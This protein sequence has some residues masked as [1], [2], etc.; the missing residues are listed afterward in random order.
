MALG[1][2][3]YI[4]LSV[5]PPLCCPKK[6]GCNALFHTHARKLYHWSRRDSRLWL[7]DMDRVWLQLMRMAHAL[8]DHRFAAGRVGV[9]AQTLNAYK[10]I[11]KNARRRHGDSGDP[12]GPEMLAAV[13]DVELQ[14][15]KKAGYK[16]MAAARVGTV[17]TNGSVPCA[18]GASRPPGTDQQ[19]VQQAEVTSLVGVTPTVPACSTP[20]TAMRSSDPR[21][22]DDASSST[23]S[24]S[25]LSYRSGRHI[26]DNLGIESESSSSCSA[27]AAAA[28]GADKSVNEH[29]RAERRAEVELLRDEVEI[30]ERQLKSKQLELE[31]RRAEL[32]LRMKEQA[33]EQA[34][35]TQQRNHDHRQQAQQA[36][37]RRERRKRVRSA[38]PPP[39][40]PR[41]PAAPP[42]PPARP[43]LPSKWHKKWHVDGSETRKNGGNV[44]IGGSFRV[45]LPGD[46]TGGIWF[47]SGPADDAE[48]AQHL[49]ERQ[50]HNELVYAC[51][52]YAA[53]AVGMPSVP[54]AEVGFVPYANRDVVQGSA[55]ARLD[56]VY[57]RPTPS[58]N[59]GGGGH[60]KFRK[61]VYEAI[62][63]RQKEL[64]VPMG[65]RLAKMAREQA[66][67]R[68]AEYDSRE[69]GSEWLT[70]EIAGQRC[71]RA[72]APPHV[73]AAARRVTELL[74]G[75]AMQG[76]TQQKDKTGSTP[77]GCYQLY[78][79]Y[80][81]GNQI[82]CTGESP[83]DACF[84]V[85]G[86]QEPDAYMRNS[87][88]QD[89]VGRGADQ[90]RACAFAESLTREQL[91]CVKMPGDVRFCLLPALLNGSAR[92][93]HPEFWDA[94]QPI[95]AWL[96]EQ[97]GGG[98]YG[99][100][101]PV[102]P[103][104]EYM[105][106]RGATNLTI[107]YTIS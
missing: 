53:H 100:D 98:S 36:G 95:L 20:P 16:D 51:P 23:P 25:N 76:V 21:T 75:G 10:M 83:P 28:P 6:E 60:S 62:V 56:D 73:V 35:K 47:S 94:M 59:E 58:R 13:M 69:P 8:H 19:E 12:T 68:Q 41:A 61:L 84:F 103:D 1:S 80:T 99:S 54:G 91:M 24:S 48:S 26:F 85:R 32:D 66:E 87:H 29:L 89:G 86:S 50:G 102:H 71:K 34:R 22:T 38:T 55:M 92:D 30:K 52:Q 33:A 81:N 44:G 18:R 106:L 49:V 46:I 82:M 9:G 39:P 7:A 4:P 63:A 101:N 5:H 77:S 65:Y 70:D 107:T 67:E 14:L 17:L 2:L 88:G 57:C 31:L 93:E 45:H 64:Q 3:G 40:P 96:N 37:E 15:A 27:A 72:T 90:E 74:E 42:Q 97:W 11:V 105:G 79:G 78:L 104:H 43:Q